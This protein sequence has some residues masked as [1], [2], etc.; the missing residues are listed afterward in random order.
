MV[1]KKSYGNLLLLECH[2]WNRLGQYLP[3]LNT[4]KPTIFDYFILVRIKYEQRNS[5]QLY[6]LL[7]ESKV[8][9]NRLLQ[10]IGNMTWRFDIP[11][12]LTHNDLLKIIKQKQLLPQGSQLNKT[13]MDANNYYAQSGDLR[14]LEKLISEMKNE[15]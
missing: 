14:S 6:R 5:S 15:L 1:I 2:D 10:L 13:K 12:Y 9:R 7:D 3:N 11:G 4:E 8:E